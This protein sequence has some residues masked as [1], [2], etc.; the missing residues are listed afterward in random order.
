MNN[1]NLQQRRNVAEKMR[2]AFSTQPLNKQLGSTQKS[3][4]IESINFSCVY[5]PL[6]SERKL[7]NE[8]VTKEAD[9]RYKHLFKIQIEVPG[10]KHKVD[11]EYEID[12][13]E[14]NK[15]L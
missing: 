2:R 8:N 3:L 9:K 5:A 12:E 11:L 13:V 14:L 7:I 6:K 1:F 10:T 4:I 15:I